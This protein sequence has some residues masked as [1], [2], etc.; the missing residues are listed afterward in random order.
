MQSLLQ[1]CLVRCTVAGG[2]TCSILTW[3][4]AASVAAVVVIRLAI[5]CLSFGAA[6]LSSWLMFKEGFPGIDCADTR[7]FRTV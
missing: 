2:G 3:S 5:I 1:P 4:W 7:A 6:S